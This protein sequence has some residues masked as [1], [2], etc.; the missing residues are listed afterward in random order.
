VVVAENLR[1][2]APDGRDGV[3]QPVAVLDLVFVEDLRDAGLGQDVSERQPLVARE[4]GTNRIQTC[5][6]IAF[7]VSG[8]G[9]APWVGGEPVGRATGRHPILRWDSR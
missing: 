8:Q 7:D 5:H 4:A 3:E 6:R 2:E 9:N 1:E